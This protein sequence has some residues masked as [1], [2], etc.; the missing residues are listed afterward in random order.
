MKIKLE[1]RAFVSRPG[2]ERSCCFPG[3]CAT[4]GGRI[5][6]TARLGPNKGGVT[7][8]RVGLVYSDDGGAS[9]S[10]VLYPFA[11]PPV[12]GRPGL[13]RAAFLTE[14]A[15][16]EL[17]AEIGWVD[18]S[19]PELP[20]FNPETE[21]LLDM[22][23][24]FSRS[25]DGGLTWSK[26]ELVDT[27][28]Y[29]SPTPLTGAPLLT[30]EGEVVCQF[31]LNK[32]YDETETWRH[33]SVLM[34]SRDGGRSFYRHTVTSND[35]ENR[36]FY[37][38]QRPG[39]LRDGSV[40][41]YFWSYDN[42]EGRYINIRGRFSGD[43]GRTFSPIA[44]LGFPGQPANPVQLPDGRVVLFY[45][46]RE[47]APTVKY[48]I[49]SADG[50]SFDPASETVVASAAGSQ[51]Q[52]KGIMADAWKEMTAFSLGLPAAATAAGGDVLLVYYHGPGTDETS[53]EFVRFGQ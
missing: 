32:P 9:W 17:L 43:H 2:E 51:N 44:D 36:F 24:F 16:G 6:V 28:P 34:F 7:G 47:A 13:F 21:G 20:F 5:I 1:S 27:A 19:N 15:P 14:I 38:D 41:D 22:R 46:D 48:R 23:I 50:R 25:F 33:S 40:A 31:E 37:W 11:P 18:H 49:G 45:V 29:P 10:E 8:Q 4:A 26:P 30:G 35:P 12:D 42:R 53:I 52:A 39:V 3:V